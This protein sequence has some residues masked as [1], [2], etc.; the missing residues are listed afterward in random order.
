MLHVAMY[1][2]V[3]PQNTGAV[4]RQCVGMNA[5]LHLIGPMGFE[6]TDHAVK[7]AGLDYWPYLHLTE[8]ADEAAFYDWL[9][10]RR[11]WLITKFGGTRFDRADYE[12]EDVLMVGN[13]NHGLP[14]SIHERHSGTRVSIPMP[15][16]SLGNVRSYNVSNAAA[17]VMAMAMV[18]IADSDS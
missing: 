5:H 12:D 18:R 15:G 17:I 9:G 10:E 6:I 1:R 14:E 4:A 16:T 3:I 2:P 7:R 13:E 8:Y 11:V